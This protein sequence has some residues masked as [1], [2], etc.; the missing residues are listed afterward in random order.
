MKRSNLPGT[1]HSG[2]SGGSCLATLRVLNT[3]VLHQLRPLLLLVEQGCRTH[4]RLKEVTSCLCFSVLGLSGVLGACS[5]Q[6]GHKLLCFGSVS[7]C[8]V[9]STDPQPFSEAGSRVSQLKTK[10]NVSLLSLSLSAGRAGMHQDLP[11]LCG[12]GANRGLVQAKRIFYQPRSIPSIASLSPCFCLRDFRCP[13]TDAL[14]SC[15]NLTASKIPT[16]V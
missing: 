7:R 4:A 3:G 11:G 1:C 10:D 9:L 8:P 5:S 15:L 2:I 14:R 12:A 16:P 6:G 13:F